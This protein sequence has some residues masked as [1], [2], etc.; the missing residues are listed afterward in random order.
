MILLKLCKSIL[1]YPGL[2]KHLTNYLHKKQ[3]CALTLQLLNRFTEY[4]LKKLAL[5]Y[6]VNFTKGKK[7]IFVK[8]VMSC[9]IQDK[10]KIISPSDMQK[11]H[12][13][14]E[15]RRN[16]YI[17]IFGETFYMICVSQSIKQNCHL[18]C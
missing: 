5:S 14:Q 13:G 18:E 6:M 1:I 7:A 17:S 9:L 11:K 10:S 16:V 8:I 15:K 12:L 3:C 4:N 2:V